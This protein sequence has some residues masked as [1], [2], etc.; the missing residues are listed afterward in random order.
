MRWMVTRIDLDASYR[1]K[2]RFRSDQELVLTVEF[3]GVPPRL[4]EYRA[5]FLQWF[6]DG[7]EPW[8]PKCKAYTGCA[9][10]FDN[11]EPRFFKLEPKFTLPPLAARV[12]DF[13]NRGLP[14]QVGEVCHW[15]K[16]GDEV[17]KVRILKVLSAVYEVENIGS[18]ADYPAILKAD[19]DKLFPI[20]DN[21]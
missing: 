14:R 2:V 15:I 7:E 3:P 17:R 5:K 16:N 4:E 1:G 20:W 6:D 8:K 13:H 12:R 21:I 18:G 11:L 10:K 9:E 19:H